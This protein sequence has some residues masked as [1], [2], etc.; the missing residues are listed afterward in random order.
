MFLA[1]SL[2]WTFD[3]C[4]LFCILISHY[5]ESLTLGRVPCTCSFHIVPS[6]H[7]AYR[8]M[9]DSVFYFC[10]VYNGILW[11]VEVKLTSM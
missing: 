9:C 7:E 8:E 11:S 2:P 10:L 3:S 1:P 5:S 6:L 4:R